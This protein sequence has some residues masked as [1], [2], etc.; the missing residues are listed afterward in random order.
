MVPSELASL[1]LSHSWSQ[2]N[3]CMLASLYRKLPNK[4]NNQTEMQESLKGK[5]DEEEEGEGLAIW[6]CGSPLYDSY[7]LVS[8]THIIDRHLMALPHLDGSKRFISANNVTCT[9]MVSKASRGNSTG[10]AMNEFDVRKMWKR[11]VSIGEGRNEK[12]KRTKTWLSAF[13]KRIGSWKK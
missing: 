12:P 2:K 13:Y 4:L 10:S 9:S 7:E 5:E 6:D 11:K 8:L 1:N 3:K